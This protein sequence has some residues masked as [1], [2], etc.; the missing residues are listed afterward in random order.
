MKKTPWY[1]GTILPE[2]GAK[3]IARVI[4]AAPE[5]LDAAGCLSDCA[6]RLRYLG[7]PTTQNFHN[8]LIAAIAKATGEKE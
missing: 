8:Q 5:L 1:P 6:D 7:I 2:R 4:M 3:S